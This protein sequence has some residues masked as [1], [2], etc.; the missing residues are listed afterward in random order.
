MLTFKM[1]SLIRFAGILF[2]LLFLI[3]AFFNRPATDDFHFM[4]NLHQYGIWE[5]MLQEYSTW[6]PRY[7]SVL[8]TQSIL[9]LE[10][11]TGW[12]YLIYGVLSLLLSWTA[13]HF[14]INRIK[15]L[16]RR[17][18]I[19]LIDDGPIGISTSLFICSI[20]FLSTFRIGETWFWLCSSSTYLWSN[21]FLL[22]LMGSVIHEK[23]SVKHW[24]VITISSIYIGGSCGPLS[25]LT[26][27]L[28]TGV[29][30]V[31]TTKWNPFENSQTILKRAVFSLLVLLL[32]FTVQYLAEGN[33]IREQ[34]FREISLVESFILNIKM[35]GIILLKR[36]PLSL[37]I[38]LALTFP[39]LLAVKQ[40]EVSFTKWVRAI[41]LSSIIYV[42][43][44]FL[45]Q[46]SITYKTQDVGAYRTLFFVNT[47]SVIFC[48]NL[49]VQSARYGIIDSSKLFW[50]TTKKVILVCYS[51]TLLFL[52]FQQA[53]YGYQYSKSCD[54]RI[55]YCI[56]ACNQNKNTIIL[57][58]LPYSGMLYSAELSTDP[59][60]FSNE[61]YVQGLN[62]T[63]KVRRNPF[64]P[65]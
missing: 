30:S 27:V 59:S 8:I 24:L 52:L 36:L 19:D 45:F 11:F 18:G 63:C 17:S 48:A 29:I 6:S 33:R 44:I 1:R 43:L 51:I 62:I 34:F 16:L 15:E 23:Q 46:W 53:N 20:W 40:K 3:L 12:G 7:C 56:K 14:L 35:T 25:I 22:F 26:L 9:S 5:G 61:H 60:F 50:S 41:T 2:F 31:T 38:S 55:A 42:G 28:L 37:L 13:V 65:E 39:L 58:P 47:L 10:E 4:H 64:P 21:A 32:A 57:H 54:S 49:W